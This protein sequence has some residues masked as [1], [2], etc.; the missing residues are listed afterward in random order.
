MRRRSAGCPRCR[1]ALIRGR[2]KKKLSAARCRFGAHDALQRS[3][4]RRRTPG[5]CPLHFMRRDSL[6][7]TQI[8][9][10]CPRPGRPG[11]TPSLERARARTH[12]KMAR[13]QGG[14][15]GARAS[16][17]APRLTRGGRNKNHIALDARRRNNMSSPAAGRATTPPRGRWRART[18]RLEQIGM[19]R[20]PRQSSQRECAGE[21][22]EPN[23]AQRRGTTN[24]LAS[25]HNLV[26]ARPEMAICSELNAPGG[27]S[28]TRGYVAAD[29]TR[30]WWHARRAFRHLEPSP[31]QKCW[32][33]RR[34]ASA[35]LKRL[36]RAHRKKFTCA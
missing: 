25:Q 18:R 27:G 4:R 10:R 9:M 1:Q 29:A 16:L 28:T 24:R 31:H 13:A 26:R 17:A 15:H 6:T 34:S 21:F 22:R 35:G 7:G 33:C 30:Q 3:R 20:R 36:P 2:T 11:C 23:W 12:M 14:T 19:L 5:I 32:Q 8:L